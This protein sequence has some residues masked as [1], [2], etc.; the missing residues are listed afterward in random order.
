MEE[1]TTGASLSLVLLVCLLIF[2][3]CLKPSNGKGGITPNSPATYAEIPI[4]TYLIKSDEWKYSS[5]E[6]GKWIKEFFCICG[7]GW[8]GK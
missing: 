1:V 4:S 3:P 2:V 6:K 8:M 7:Y 5:N